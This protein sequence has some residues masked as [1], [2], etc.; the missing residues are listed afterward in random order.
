MKLKI[1]FIP[2]ILIIAMTSCLD[3]LELYPTDKISSVN[4]WKTPDDALRGVNATYRY[5]FPQDDKYGLDL[6]FYE[7][8]TDNSYAQHSNQ[9]GNFQSVA[10]G[11]YEPNHEA[12]KYLWSIRYE[13]IRKCSEF[14]ENIHK[15]PMDADLA[16]RYTCEVLFQRAYAYYG[17][18]AFFGDVPWVDKTLTIAEASKIKRTDRELI[19]GYIIA[20]LDRAAAKNGLPSYY[21]DATD[22]GRATKWAALA[23][24]SRICLLMAGDY[25]ENPD[26]KYWAMA[27]EAAREV[28]KKGPHKLN[29]VAGDPIASYAPVFYDKQMSSSTK[30]V[31]YESQFN[32]ED[33][34]L[35]G[36]TVK[37]ACVS[38]GG[39][40]SWNPTQDMID[41]YEMKTTGKSIFETG[42]GYDPEN[43][44][45]DRDPRLTASIYYP[46]SLTLKGMVYNSQPAS[47][48]P[49][50]MDQHNGTK[51]GYG[52]RKYL[53]ELNLGM[54]DSGNDFPLIR[55]SEVVLNFAEAKNEE[56]GA[57]DAEVRSAVNYVRQRVGMPSLPTGLSKDEMRQ[58]IRNE[59]RVELAF[60]GTRFFDIRRWKIAHEVLNSTDGWI[61]GMKL[62]NPGN[63]PVDEQGRIKVSK[64]HFDKNKHYLFPIPQREVELN[65]NLLPNNPGWN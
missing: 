37:L 55:L 61:I 28:W 50:R 29:Y 47:G 22:D 52:W 21:P 1:F 39:W 8:A 7:S 23:L 62:E 36:F 59:R 2:I 4:F 43:P 65:P 10:L 49:D 14:L 48:S 16:E 57:P 26:S 63:Y 6:F 58:R 32:T 3:N 17:L 20:D 64:R 18:I 9:F 54:W 51:T 35:F 38:D 25:R 60:E 40:N 15:V 33:R 11:Y 45:K 5:T 30:E 44:Y 41:A 56:L 53:D 19:A 34:P 13:C 24:K 42:S 27:A 31:I 46:G 12:I